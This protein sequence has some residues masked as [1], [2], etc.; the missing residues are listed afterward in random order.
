MAFRMPATSSIEPANTVQP[1]RPDP[2]LV[3]VVILC[4]FPRGFPPVAWSQ[5][6]GYASCAG[7]LSRRP[8]VTPAAGA[9][10]VSG[11]HQARAPLRARRVPSAR[12]VSRTPQ[13]RRPTASRCPS[14]STCPSGSAPRPPAE[15]ALPPPPPGRRP[16]APGRAGAPPGDRQQRQVE[17]S[18]ADLGHP[19][20][21]LRVA[22]EVDAA[23]AAGEHVAE[24]GRVRAERHP[25][26][27]VLGVHRLHLERADR[28]RLSRHHLGGGEP[29][30][31]Q[32]RSSAARC[33]HRH[34]AADPPDR[35]RRGGRRAGGRSAPRPP[36]AGCPGRTRRGGAGGRRVVA[37]A[38]R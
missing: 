30:A 2:A 36:R 16:C 11:W 15:A 18:A 28:R 38:D 10:T 32:E 7:N 25:L 9:V 37:A 4:S 13:A 21:Q 17:P 33:H 6:G 35:R 12:R 24:R 19:R 34:V 8:R 26:A 27:V 3:E 14:P 22:G 5:A 1:D 31:A 29:L 23:A 20:E